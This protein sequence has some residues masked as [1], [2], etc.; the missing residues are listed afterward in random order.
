MNKVRLNWLQRT[1]QKLRRASKPCQQTNITILLV[2]SE[3]VRVLASAGGN[4]KR[5]VGTIGKIVMHESRK[6][7]AQKVRFGGLFASR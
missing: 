4:L 6:F 5:I 1:V 3:D 7:N 2:E